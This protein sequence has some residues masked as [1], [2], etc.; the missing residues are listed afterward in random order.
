M[1][2]N[3]QPGVDERVSVTLS[4]SEALLVAIERAVVDAGGDPRAGV[5]GPG[6]MTWRINRESALF[7]GAGRA[8]LLQLAHPWVVAALEQHSNVMAQPIARFH[9]TFRIVFAMVF[10][11]LDQALAAARH[12]FAL[13]TGIRGDMPEDV[14]GYRRGSAYEAN[15]VGA[16]RWVYATLI[17]SAVLAYEAVM[18]PLT[19]GELTDYYMEMKTLGAL[20]GIRGAALPPDWTAFVAYCREMAQSN[21]LGVSRGARAMAHGLLAGSNSWLKLPNWYRALTVQWLPERL[22]SEFRLGFDAPDKRAAARVA[23][24]LPRWY[25]RLP[26]AVRFVGPYHEAQARLQRQPA[27]VAARLSNR[28]WIGEERLPFG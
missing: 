13:H 25:G 23:E 12:L 5:F 11:S 14:A 4:D 9:N 27:G 18:P 21:A 1:P 7:L 22:R 6:S 3:L 17:E 8:A 2:P 19:F 28:F 24:R 16:L 26:D 20:F 10:G 15:E